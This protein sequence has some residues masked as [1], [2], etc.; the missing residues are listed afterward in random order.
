LD[1]KFLRPWSVGQLKEIWAAAGV[2]T[3][4]LGELVEPI[5]APVGLEADRLYT[6]LKVTY[7]GQAK[8]GENRLGREVTY[9]RVQETT[10]NDIV[11]SH[12]NA[13]NRATCVVPPDMTGL[14]VSPEFTILRVRPDKKTRIDPFYLWHVLRSAA[15]VAEFL[16]S[17]TGKGRHRVEWKQ[18]RGQE[19]PMIPIEKQLSIGSRYREMLEH[20]RAASRIKAEADAQLEDLALDGPEAVDRL[21]RAKPPR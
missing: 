10:E 13:V 18:L 5:D 21:E 1:A 2:S 6:F 3:A 19:I 11:V 15:V 7:E 12:I 9:K 8:R 17:A 16:T 20:E 14:L 4:R